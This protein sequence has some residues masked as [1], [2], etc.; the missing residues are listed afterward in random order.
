MTDKNNNSNNIKEWL[1]LNI[2]NFANSNE[3]KS[4]LIELEFLKDTL[5]EHFRSEFNHEHI[6]LAK[7]IESVEIDV[8]LSVSD[9]SQIY[10]NGIGHKVF[11]KNIR[12]RHLHLKE[13]YLITFLIH[14]ADSSKINIIRAVYFFLCLRMVELTDYDSRI[15]TT[16]DECRF[17]TNKTRSFLI[18]FLPDITEF[19]NLQCIKEYLIQAQENDNYTRWLNRSPEA[20]EL[21]I[22]KYRSKILSVNVELYSSEAQSEINERIAHY[23]YE[24]ILPLENFFKDDSGITRI[25]STTY[26]VV[27]GES[28]YDD[29]TKNTVSDLVNIAEEVSNNE[30]FEAG[31]RQD[32]EKES[33]EQVLIADPSNYYID[34]VRAEG[35]LNSRRK[36]AMSQV[37]DV[38][39]AHEDEIRVLVEHIASELSKLDFESID[40]EYEY[41]HEYEEG[42]FRFDISQQSVL[43]LYM[44][45]LTGIHDIYT[46][47]QLQLG[48]EGY[49]F[50]LTFK[51]SRSHI[52]DDWDKSLCANNGRDLYLFMPQPVGLMHVEMGQDAS[53]SIADDIYA[54]AKVELQ[55]LNKKFGLRLSI[56]KIK[57]YLSHFLTQISIDKALIEVLTGSPVHHH[58]ALPY[59]NTSQYD[60]FRCQREYMD[61]LITLLGD[62][63]NPDHAS[64]NIYKLFELPDEELTSY[65]DKNIGSALAINQIKLEEIVIKLRKEV[66]DA[67]TNLKLS[68][69]NTI[70]SLHNY[71]MDYLY[72]LMSIASGYR[73][74]TEPFGRLLDID[75]RT[76]MYFIS[77]K[78]VQLDAIGRFIYLP[79]IVCQQ[80]DE[81]I[82]FI[83]ING[84]LLNK[85]D[86]DLGHIYIDILEGKIGLITYLKLDVLTNTVTEQRLESTFL[87]KRLSTYIMLPLNWHRHFIRSLRS[88]DIG[89]YSFE[90]Y[91]SDK[92]LGH[93]VV[94]AWMGHSDE[95]GFSFYDRFSGLKRSNLREFAQML[96]EL[97]DK[98]GF[99]TI[100][101]ELPR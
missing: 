75:T 91:L 64:S 47:E 37:T 70:V 89:I 11:L 51:P 23:L 27:S 78:E 40:K 28:Y 96:N 30:C 101:L 22:R 76:G 59:F 6:A 7:W 25:T 72:I 19:K 48:F 5:P 86:N 80:I 92:P 95:L 38:N 3:V 65:W 29:K 50:Q 63:Y 15:I 99:K 94:S 77:D 31:E 100:Q 16:L 10:E 41:E 98:I 44:L 56:N 43:Y 67:V 55:E 84:N 81:Y 68:K 93:D 26:H 2:L 54:Q 60:L 17:L 69:M 13:L 9:E 18:Y 24:Y 66:E 82:R 32:D 1:K 88:S 52:D 35:Q 62:R 49:R 90:T 46:S 83:K 45:L 39:S 87:K 58:S 20:F 53:D 4:L 61:H 33:F 79:K 12:A 97:L 71:F 8:S 34:F 85:L 42:K 74:V 36:N 14:R 21:E 57:N 73:P